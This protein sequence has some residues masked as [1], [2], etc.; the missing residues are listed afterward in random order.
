VVVALDNGEREA[1]LI[2]VDAALD[3]ERRPGGGRLRNV[4]PNDVVDA[5]SLEEQLATPLVDQLRTHLRGRTAGIL[6]Q[7]RLR[8]EL[9][10]A[11]DRRGDVAG[12]EIR[13]RRQQD[14]FVAARDR[15]GGGDQ[16]V[17]RGPPD[18]RLPVLTVHTRVDHRYARVRNATHRE[19]AER[20]IDG[21]VQPTEELRLDEV[22]T[23]GDRLRVGRVM[24]VVG[25][26]ERGVGLR[27]GELLEIDSCACATNAGH[28]QDVRVVGRLRRGDRLGE[29]RFRL[30]ED[31]SRRELR[32]AIDRRTAARLAEQHERV[33]RVRCRR[34]DE[35][36][37][38]R[39]LLVRPSLEC[40][41][42]LVGR[43]PGDREG[44]VV[45]GDLDGPALCRRIRRK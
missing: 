8:A 11:R 14:G 15:N 27:L 21:R 22:F 12:L 35:E 23:A 20:R 1:D 43:R 36:L 37:T 17:L 4:E 2:P 32:S 16:R 42:D 10:D 28:V 9:V 33:T 29:S 26:H 41:G 44:C 40:R 3:R 19:V 7:R 18:S 13:L 5:L 45:G 39:H 6:R 30:G 31:L 38:I 24:H 34:R 25:W